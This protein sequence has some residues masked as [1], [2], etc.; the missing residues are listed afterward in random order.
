MKKAILG[1]ALYGLFHTKQGYVSAQKKLYLSQ[2]Q[3]MCAP[4]ENVAHK[5]N[6]TVIELDL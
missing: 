3:I 4:E 5:M 1:L 2:F 6:I